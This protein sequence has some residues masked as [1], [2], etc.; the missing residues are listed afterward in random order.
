MLRPQNLDLTSAS[1]S[2]THLAGGGG[3]GGGGVER[4]TRAGPSQARQAATHL[5]PSQCAAMTVGW[6]T[7]FSATNLHN[8]HPPNQLL[9]LVRGVQPPKQQ[10]AH[11]PEPFLGIYELVRLAQQWVEGLGRAPNRAAVRAAA[12]QWFHLSDTRRR[13]RQVPCTPPLPPPP[14]RPDTPWHLT[15]KAA[16][17]S[18][19]SMPEG[20]SSA[21]SSSSSEYSRSSAV[22]CGVVVVRGCAWWHAAWARPRPACAH[23]HLQC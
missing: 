2:N 18:R 3:G 1:P 6:C 22:F 9:R 7:T 15:A 14:P 20:G 16:T 17:R 19:R 5:R 4:S 13:P 21:A 10:R 12:R 8:R 23:A 11:S